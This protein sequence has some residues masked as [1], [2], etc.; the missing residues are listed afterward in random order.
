MPN[1]GF[2]ICVTAGRARN[3]FGIL[4]ILCWLSILHSNCKITTSYTRILALHLFLHF[5]TH[6]TFTNT[7]ILIIPKTQYLAQTHSIFRR[8]NIIE[9]LLTAHIRYTDFLKDSTG[10]FN[11]N[12]LCFFI[13]YSNSILHHLYIPS[14]LLSRNSLSQH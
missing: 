12:L 5:H 3:H 13:L 6:L 1:C 10:L 9:I 14:I 4:L 7:Y 11:F 2:Q 8:S